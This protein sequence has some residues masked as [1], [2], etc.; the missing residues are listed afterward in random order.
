MA[1]LTIQ[2]LSI[3]FRQGGEERQVVDGLSL[4]VDAGETLALV[5]ESGSGK[6]VT[7][8]SVMRLLPTPPVVYPQ[9]DILFDGQSVLRADE[10]T[11]R[12]LR[13]NRIAMI[14]Q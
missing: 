4:S 3:A 12:G 9:G 8:L 5:G 14:F 13:G 10:R 2:D 6:S 7:A 1:L 11:L